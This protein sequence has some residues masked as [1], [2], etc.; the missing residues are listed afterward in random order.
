MHLA[1]ATQ[2]FGTTAGHFVSSRVFAS[3][4]FGFTPKCLVCASYNREE[5]LYIT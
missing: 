2:I 3:S 5:M 4:V 1:L